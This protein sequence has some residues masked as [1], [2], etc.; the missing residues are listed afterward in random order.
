MDIKEI[1]IGDVFYSEKYSCKI[2]VIALTTTNEVVGAW[3]DEEGL[4]H[5][6]IFSLE[7]LK[8]V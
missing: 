3:H 6:E 8:N 5:Q 2:T 1:K 4:P 7:D